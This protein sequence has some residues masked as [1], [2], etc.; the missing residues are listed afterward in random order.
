MR[1]PFASADVVFTGFLPYGRLV[2][3][4]YS[5]HIFYSPSRV[6][7]DGGTEGGAPVTIVEIS[8]TDMPVVSTRQSRAA[9]V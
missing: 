8:A 5:H 7:E 3:L 9:S 4:A 1:L 2:E 6:A